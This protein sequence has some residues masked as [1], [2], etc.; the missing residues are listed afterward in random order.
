MELIASIFN[1]LVLLKKIKNLAISALFNSIRLLINLSNRL[2][3]SMTIFML[4]AIT[5]LAGHT[6]SAQIATP[7]PSLLTLGSL[8]NIPV[9]EPSNLNEFLVKDKKTGVVDK[10]PAIALGKALFWDMQVGSDGIQSCASCHFH[11]GAD[12]RIKNQLSPGLLQ[13]NTDG[14]PNQDRR[15]DL[16]GLNYTLKPSDYP[17]HKLADPNNRNSTVIS[18]T[19]DITSSQGVTNA[20]FVDVVPGSAQ[21]RVNY[22]L[23]EVFNIGGTNVRRVQP[24]NTPTVINSIFNFRNFWDGS[25]PNDFNGINEVGAKDI[26]AKLF[27]AESFGKLTEVR[28]NLDNAS[29]ASQALGPPL[30]SFETSADGRTF[31]EIGD[32]FGSIDRNFKDNARGKKLP[33]KLG[34]KTLPLRPL[35]KQIVH[36]EDSVLGK[37]S[38]VPRL[39]LKTDS[40]EKL[41]EQAFQSQWW[42]S[43]RMI[44]ISDDGT[45][46]VVKKPDRN[47]QT[48]EY[49]LAEY[50]FPLFFG[51]AVQL[52]EATLVSDD[53]PFDRFQ[54]GNYSALTAQQQQGLEIFLGQ[55][56]NNGG[57]RCIN[58]HSGTEFTDASVSKVSKNPLRRREGNIIDRGFN[59]IGVRPT[60]ED[61]GV[62]D[63]DRFDNPLSTARLAVQGS[64]SDPTLNP[65]I[66][67]KDILGVDGAFKTPGLRNVELTAPYFHNGGQSTLRQVVDFYAR[68]GDFQPILSR[69]GEIKPLSTLTLGKTPGEV[70]QAKEALVAFLQSLTDD[71]VR[72]QK[73]PFD[74]PQLW[75]TDGHPGNSTSVTNDGSGKA[76]D[77]MKEIVAVGRNGGAPLPNFLSSATSSN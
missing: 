9:P 18:D 33:R 49:T 13:V 15:V 53:T 51:L 44:Q 48:N 55:D 64:F 3:K 6:V 75:V 16:G 77:D 36:P 10:T 50:N 73:A 62:G 30:S 56:Q 71:R 70:E 47:L 14:T 41:I 61:L 24:R 12:S 58:C 4:V 19:N 8:K 54:A 59:N 67:S 34:K 60:W 42:K 21:D 29:L 40:Y 28:V 45:R 32:K 38:N 39:G 27:K 26:N 2:K 46:T 52:Y 1:R 65:P 63:L 23:D 37:Y 31:V 66:S 35:G 57:G 72:Y 76:T 69:D 5:V 20:E 25:A 17:F 7:S 43:N 11:A 68:G 22:K 74:H